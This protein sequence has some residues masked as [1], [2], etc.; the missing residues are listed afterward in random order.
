MRWKQ[1]QR[2]Q[3]EDLHLLPGQQQSP[4]PHAGDDGPVQRRLHHGRG[5]L[6]VQREPV[7]A[8]PGMARD[9]LERVP[10]LHALHLKRGH[11]IWED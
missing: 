4:A 2:T 6:R 5:W 3:Q 1:Q 10:S 9:R 11:F 7:G 8:G